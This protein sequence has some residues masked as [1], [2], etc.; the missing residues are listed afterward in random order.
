M[1]R[2]MSQQTNQTLTEPMQIIEQSTIAKNPTTGNED[3]IVVTNDFIAVID[4]STSKSNWQIN[5]D[6][7]NGR[8]CMMLISQ[9]ISQCRYDITL[10]ELCT[11]I[12]LF[13]RKHYPEDRLSE[14]DVHPEAQWQPAAQYIVDTTTKYG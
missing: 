3:G 14:V 13:V 9:F 5:P 2:I 1:H 11:D 8:Y 10:E 4:G 6:M 12:T 7:S